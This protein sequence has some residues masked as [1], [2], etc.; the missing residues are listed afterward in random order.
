MRRVGKTPY[1]LIEHPRFRA[2]LDF[3]VLRAEAG[4]IEEELATWWCDF[5]ASDNV[6]RANLMSDLTLVKTAKKS[7]KKTA[8]PR[9]TKAQKNS[10]PSTEAKTQQMAINSESKTANDNTELTTPDAP[11]KRRRRKKT[12]IENDAQTAEN[13]DTQ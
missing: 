11:K 3:L 7:T 8:K 10:V 5:F 13:S 2:G 12:A 4:E 6:A 1:K 9:P